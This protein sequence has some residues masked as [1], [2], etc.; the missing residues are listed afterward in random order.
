[1]WSIYSK[2]EENIKRLVQGLKSCD[3]IPKGK[4]LELSI[5]EVDLLELDPLLVSDL[6]QLTLQHV[7]LTASTVNIIIFFYAHLMEL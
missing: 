3:D 6:Q 5:S 2:K 4:L 7:T 1:M